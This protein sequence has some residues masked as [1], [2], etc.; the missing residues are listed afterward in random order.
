MKKF[1]SLRKV[2]IKVIPSKR[3]LFELNDLGFLCYSKK[4]CPDLSGVIFSGR[5][6]WI[7][8]NPY[9]RI[10]YVEE[11]EETVTFALLDGKFAALFMSLWRPIMK[12]EKRSNRAYAKH[13]AMDVTD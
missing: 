9:S 4:P 5:I 2:R 13:A 6:R 8:E 12:R 11:I 3:N 1:A 10:F 7:S